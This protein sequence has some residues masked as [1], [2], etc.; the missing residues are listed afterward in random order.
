[1]QCKIC[2]AVQLVLK[3]NAFRKSRN[4]PRV[5][6]SAVQCGIENFEK[7]LKLTESTTLAMFIALNFV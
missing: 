3:N 2:T 5:Q 6:C 1:M 4:I 7:Q